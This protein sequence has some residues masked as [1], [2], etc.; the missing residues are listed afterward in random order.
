MALNKTKI[1]AEVQIAIAAA[2]GRYLKD[3]KMAFHVA[4][5]KPI[6]HGKIN[7]WAL[8]GRQDMMTGFRKK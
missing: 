8:S 5:V 3:D 2:L 6:Q 1:S 4:S 7:L